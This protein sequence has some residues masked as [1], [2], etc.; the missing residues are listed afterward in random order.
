V[1]AKSIL[2][3]SL[4]VEHSS[5]LHLEEF[6]P[7]CRICHRGYFPRDICGFR[8]TVENSHRFSSDY[9]TSSLQLGGGFCLMEHD[10]HAPEQGIYVYI[11]DQLPGDRICMLLSG[12]DTPAIEVSSSEKSDAF[13]YR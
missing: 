7:E 1:N 10:V 3:K 4:G 11:S 13:K 6:H 9:D 2:R 8:A 12:I 5:K